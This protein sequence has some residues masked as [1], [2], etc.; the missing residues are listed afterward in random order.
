MIQSGCVCV[1]IHVQL[2]S[3]LIDHSLTVSS[4]HGILQ[5]RELKWVA[6]SFSR[7]SSWPRDQAHVSCIS[8]I[9]MQILYHWHHLGSFHNLANKWKF[10]LSV[11]CYC[12][13]NKSD[14][15]AECPQFSVFWSW[16]IIRCDV[17]SWVS[18]FG[19]MKPTVNR[20]TEITCPDISKLLSQCYQV[21]TFKLFC[22][23]RN[24]KPY[25]FKSL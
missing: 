6:I 15:M 24:I 21:P 9:D 16:L 19:P 22:C 17:W 12:F 3:D 23:L 18:H 5:A 4:V 1:L 10:A 7:G 13:P 11:L 14:G 2:F 20:I 25:L 8:C